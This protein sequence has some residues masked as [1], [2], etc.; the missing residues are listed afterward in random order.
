MRLDAETDGVIG[1][2]EL[3]LDIYGLAGGS[4]HLEIHVFIFNFSISFIGLWILYEN[5][6]HIII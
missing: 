3:N 4:L 2:Y 1:V 5:A 6:A